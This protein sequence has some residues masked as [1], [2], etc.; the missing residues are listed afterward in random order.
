VN[1]WKKGGTVVWDELIPISTVAEEKSISKNTPPQ[2]QQYVKIIME[3][4]LCISSSLLYLSLVSMHDSGSTKKQKEG[5]TI[6]NEFHFVNNTLYETTSGKY[7]ESSPTFIIKLMK[8]VVLPCMIHSLNS[9]EVG[10]S[11]EKK[12]GDTSF[13]VDAVRHVK[14][15]FRLLWDGARH[16]EDIMSSSSTK[17][18]SQELLRMSCL[19]LQSEGIQFITQVLNMIYT[20]YRSLLSKKS[21]SSSS[22][23]IK[24]LYALFDR[25]AAS[26]MKSV[27]MF[28]KSTSIFTSSS[29]NKSSGNESSL[30]KKKKSALLHFHRL[31][32]DELDSVAVNL[33]SS[34]MPASYYEYC[35][36]RSIHQWRL[37]SS[38]GTKRVPILDSSKQAKGSSS[39]SIES[40]VSSMTYSIVQLVLEARYR[41]Q[42]HNHKELP[43]EED[44]EHVISTF[45]SVIINN[46]NC[47]P[48]CLNRCRSMIMMLNLQREATGLITA[49][50]QQS[51]LTRNESSIN[52]LASVL[53]QCLAPLEYKLSRLT[54][55]QSR[56]LNFRLS[57][58]DCCAKSASLY[59]I[60][61][62][63]QSGGDD[64]GKGYTNKAESQLSNAYDILVK[65]LGRLD[66]E[67]FDRKAP[68]IVAIE[69]FAKVSLKILCRSVSRLLYHVY[70]Q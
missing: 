68:S 23:G 55:D 42:S 40:T 24:E 28:E 9:T 22:G 62:A 58:A 2:Q 43:N 3:S 8:S 31:V 38:I 19:E 15:A 60:A 36:Y 29:N 26:A 34:S 39:E 53:G 32:G 51:S 25:A 35:V 47:S 7:N 48:T 59:D 21:T 37:T 18:E 69:M 66:K 33:S 6:T 16:V 46:T 5:L 14:K 10:S 65:E 70:A 67:S 52:I 54:K 44:C 27:G 1:N 20:K 11:S 57:Y 64:E 49:T 4:G 50:Q 30:I 12:G 63:M 45:E 13:N 41:L 56:S 17:N 61:A